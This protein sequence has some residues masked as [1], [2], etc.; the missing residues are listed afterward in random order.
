MTIEITP[1]SVTITVTVV[2]ALAK[3]VHWLVSREDE[4]REERWEASLK[5][6]DEK[7]A[8]LE[9]SV[10]D[11]D[12]EL[13]GAFKAVKDTQRILFEKL[14]TH[15]REFQD[16]RLVVAEKYVAVGALKE[17]FAPL[18]ARLDSIEHDLRG[19]RSDRR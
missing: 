9:R 16:Y 11:K 17:M 5:T 6:R 7:I 19:E 2:G 18:V 10:A 15:H 1:A 12:R 4:R 3:L 8:V 13:E 14:D